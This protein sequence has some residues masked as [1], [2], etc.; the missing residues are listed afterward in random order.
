MHRA[1]VLAG[2]TISLAACA[3]AS[4]ERGVACV[5]VPE[6]R[7]ELLNVAADEVER[8]PDGSAIVGIMEDYAAMRAQSQV[9]ERATAR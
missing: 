8:L 3:T 1:I 4:S 2:A 6:Y 5:P 9:C 7:Q